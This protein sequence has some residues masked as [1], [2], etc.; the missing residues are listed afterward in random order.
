M[1]LLFI[2]IAIAAANNVDFSTRSI[3]VN[4]SLLK[5]INAPVRFNDWTNRIPCSNQTDIYQSP[6]VYISDDFT[7]SFPMAA[8]ATVFYCQSMTFTLNIM[9]VK[10]DQDPRSITYELAYHD[11]ENG[12][13]GDVFFKKTLPSPNG[14]GIWD[15]ILSV[16]YYIDL[17]VKQGDLDDSGLISFDFGNRTFLPYDTTL[18]FA[19]YTTGPRHFSSTTYRE[20]RVYWITLNT[21]GGTTPV[22]NP[23]FDSIPN[24]HYHYKDVNNLLGYNFTNWTEASIVQPYI[25]ISTKTFNLAWSAS[26]SCL[27]TT[28]L[29]NRPPTLT[30]TTVTTTTTSPTT[31]TIT[32]ETPTYIATTATMT[33]KPSIPPLIAPYNNN[34]SDAPTATIIAI[35]TNTTG[36]GDP[37]KKSLTIP[38]LGMLFFMLII[39]CVVCVLFKARE[40]KKEKQVEAMLRDNENANGLNRGKTTSLYDFMEKN[41]SDASEDEFST[42][43]KEEW[44][45]LETLSSIPLSPRNINNATT[46]TTTTAT[47]TTTT[48]MAISGWLGQNFMR[49]KD[50][51]VKDL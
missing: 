10:Q 19:F 28:Y 37:S 48:T 43:I 32:T 36:E 15:N 4:I 3:P 29:T 47:T 5:Q 27:S 2:I 18:W 7:I 49:S 12:R 35:E 30:P 39:A 24:Y 51:T 21:D 33:V 44:V 50:T 1:I 46:T 8:N 23:L 40:R 14:T 17:T 9:R 41:K 20:N 13:P 26:I 34:E 22:V 38:L 25:G 16:P 42:S 6:L 11:K 45:S 31:T